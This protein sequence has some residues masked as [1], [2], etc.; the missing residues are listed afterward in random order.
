[1]DI[2]GRQRLEAVGVNLLALAV[3]PGQDEL[4]ELMRFADVA[5]FGVIGL[6]MLLFPQTLGGKDA[7][8]KAKLQK[9]GILFLAA[10]FLFTL[11]KFIGN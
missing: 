10:T 2:A 9:A 6:L 8:K 5:F 4:M 3:H 11:A 7:Q 1:M